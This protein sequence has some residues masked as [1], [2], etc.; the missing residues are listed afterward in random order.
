LISS[1]PESWLVGL[2]GFYPV[3]PVGFEV[4]L[5]FRVE[6]KW[7]WLKLVEV[8]S[9][10]LAGQLVDFGWLGLLSRFGLG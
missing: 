8:R 1:V 7:F 5:G 6:F 10:D 2:V 4:A 9:V 3:Y